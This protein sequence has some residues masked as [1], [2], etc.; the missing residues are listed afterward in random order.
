VDFGNLIKERRKAL[1]L[2]L[3]QVGE[4]CGV[5]KSTVRKW[6]SGMIKNAGR[7]KLV[8]LSRALHLSPSDLIDT[9]GVTVVSANL[10]ADGVTL[11]D[12]ERI[13]VLKYRIAPV[14]IREAIMKL[15]E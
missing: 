11:T 1:G 8:L 5:G 15:L 4:Q 9:E 7:D 14:S 6:E 3:E 10:P 2:T 12:E 13:L